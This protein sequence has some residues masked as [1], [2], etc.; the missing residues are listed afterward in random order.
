M[1]GKTA[2]FLQTELR[3]DTSQMK[4]RYNFPPRLF[5]Y[6]ATHRPEWHPLKA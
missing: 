4:R 2:G 1:D 6:R 3:Q 5:H